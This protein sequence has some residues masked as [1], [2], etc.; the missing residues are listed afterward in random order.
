M[1]AEFADLQ[2]DES[3][4]SGSWTESA[5]RSVHD[6]VDQ[7]ILWLVTR[8][9]VLVAS[10]EAGWRQLYRDPRDGRLWELTFPHGS[11]HGGGPRRLS[12]LS[13]EVARESYRLSAADAW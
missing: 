5:A 13:R 9:L 2:P 6:H 1:S 7:R 8:R 11:L 3:L 12:V 4:L 10:A